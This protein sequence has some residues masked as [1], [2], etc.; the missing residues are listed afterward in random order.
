MSRI[1][2]YL[3]RYMKNTKRES[4]SAGTYARAMHTREFRSVRA[5]AEFVRKLP[6]IG[7]ELH[8]VRRLIH[9]DLSDKEEWMLAKILADLA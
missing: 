9:E 2:R 7:G 3:V 1:V 8:S 6:T 5:A 4:S